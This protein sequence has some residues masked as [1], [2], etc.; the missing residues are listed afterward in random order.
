MLMA[1]VGDGR[2]SV[3]E[4][5]PCELFVNPDCVPMALRV[6][7]ILPIVTVL[8]AVP[9]EQVPAVIAVGVEPSVV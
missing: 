6:S 5:E 3:Y 9:F 1:R 4:A 7:A 2:P 8:P